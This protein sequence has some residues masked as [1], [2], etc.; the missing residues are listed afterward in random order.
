MRRLRRPCSISSRSWGFKPTDPGKVNLSDFLGTRPDDELAHYFP[1]ACAGECDDD[2]GM[3]Y[4]PSN[5]TYGRIPAPP[6]SVPGVGGMGV[7]I[8]SLSG[9]LLIVFKDENPQLLW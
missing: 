6:G 2:I 3:C 4:C 5:T 8:V 7:G 9:A 1:S